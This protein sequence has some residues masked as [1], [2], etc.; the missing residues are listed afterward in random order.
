MFAGKTMTSRKFKDQ[1]NV[2]FNSGAG[3]AVRVT[4]S[5]ESLSVAVKDGDRPSTFSRLKYLANV[6]TLNMKQNTSAPCIFTPSDEMRP[7]HKTC[8][9]GLLGLLITRQSWK[10]RKPQKKKKKQ[11]S[12]IT[13]RNVKW[14]G[15]LYSSSNVQ[16]FSKN[17]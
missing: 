15:S 2:F 13:F 12:V 1:R 14:A 17:H 6:I 16:L 11:T 10:Q 7:I 4:A 9:F 3:D 5:F 8:S